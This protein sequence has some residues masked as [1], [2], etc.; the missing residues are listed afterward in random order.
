[1]PCYGSV[2]MVWDRESQQT[3]LNTLAR[4]NLYALAC[5]TMDS[6]LHIRHVDEARRDM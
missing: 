2:F 5:T 1:M 3:H 4:L 6:K